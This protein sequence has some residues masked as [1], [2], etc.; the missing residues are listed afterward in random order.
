LPPGAS[1]ILRALTNRD[2]TGPA[3]PI[4]KSTGAATP[5][6]G[7]WQIEFVSGGPKLPAAA[8]L[9]QPAS[10]T[11]LGGEDAV[12]FAG[13]ARY[14]TAFDAPG[15]GRQWRLD[16]GKVCQSARVRLNG[17]ELG[18]LLTAPFS[19]VLD[20]L[21]PT[22]NQLEVEVTSVSANAIRYYDRARVP[23]KNFR[24]INFV[25][26]NYRPFDASDWP[27]TD[28]GLIGPVTL[29]PAVPATSGQEV[30]P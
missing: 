29:V 3:Y 6:R 15:P 13:T 30:T 2:V 27:V 20:Q 1:V 18:T 24:D 14:R 5:I 22:G 12:N 10:W 11:T 8:T 21:Q 23:W 4:W 7:R 28:A 19:V 25:N 26:L 9:G 17:R 16:L